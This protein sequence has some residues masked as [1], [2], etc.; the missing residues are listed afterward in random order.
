ML[1]DYNTTRAALRL[2]DSYTASDL[3]C[4]CCTKNNLQP[5]SKIEELART[6]K[7]ALKSKDMNHELNLDS[8]SWGSKYKKTGGNRYT[9]ASRKLQMANLHLKQNSSVFWWLLLVYIGGEQPRGC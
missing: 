1:P 9:R 6:S 8:T 4:S 7:Q 5:A 3:C 2:S